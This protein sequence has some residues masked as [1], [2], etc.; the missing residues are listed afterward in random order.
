MYLPPHS[1]LNKGRQLKKNKTPR[2]AFL[3]LFTRRRI[4]KYHRKNTK[5]QKNMVLILHTRTFVQ[6]ST[7]SQLLTY[8]HIT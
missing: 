4:L 5:I 2:K 6:N 7:C 3:R 8:T 1:F